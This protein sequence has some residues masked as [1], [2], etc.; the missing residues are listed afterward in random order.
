M[1]TAWT[2]EEEKR[3]RAI[4]NYARVEED[5]QGVAFDM[6][7]RAVATVDALRAQLAAA[8]EELDKAVGFLE[9]EGYRRCDIAT[10]N[11]GRW[12]EG[13]ANRRLHEIAAVLDGPP[14]ADA[15]AA[16]RA[17]LAAARAERERLESI[18]LDQQAE[19][20]RRADMLASTESLVRWHR[21]RLAAVEGALSETV[22]CLAALA[23]P[24]GTHGHAVVGR[25]RAALKA[26][27]APPEEGGA[28]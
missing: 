2:P 16:L 8:R 3:S 22:E 6:W 20:K 19:L 15:V 17:D 14:I 24:P 18:V 21:A 25:A 10:C 9:W 5:A 27:L 11:C 4:A 13:A 26:P 12:H 7:D 23:S 28:G 1:T